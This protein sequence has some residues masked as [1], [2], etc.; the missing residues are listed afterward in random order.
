MNLQFL[1][2]SFRRDLKS[3]GYKAG[4]R[5][6]GHNTWGLV[7]VRWPQNIGKT[8]GHGCDC[9][10]GMGPVMC[11]HLVVLGP[12]TGSRQPSLGMVHCCGT[13]GGVTDVGRRGELILINYPVSYG[14]LL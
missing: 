14:S 1:H 2:D 4:E 3:C 7:L 9:Q 10:E 11:N 6:T 13:K 8:S 5:G 12:D